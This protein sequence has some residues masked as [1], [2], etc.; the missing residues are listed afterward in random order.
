MS[1][2]IIGW[3]IG[4]AHIKAALLSPD[5]KLLDLA[6]LACP[7]WK[8]LEH[9]HQ[10][11]Q[12]VLQAFSIQDGAH[13][14]TMTGE[15]VDLFENRQQGV[16]TIIQQ[17][18]RFIPAQNLLVYA[19][20]QG[21]L[22]PEQVGLPQCMNIASAN[23]LASASFVASAVEN[24]LFVDMGSTTTDILMIEAHRVQANGYTDYQ[25]LVAEELIYTGMVRT[26]VIAVAQRALFRQQEMPL[27]AEF[28]ASM[29]DVYRLTGDLNEAHDLSETAD[30]GPK[31]VSGSA[32]RLSRLT[33]YDFSPQDMSLWRTF[34]LDI[35][36][37][38]KQLIEKAIQKQ[39]QRITSRDISI[40]GAGI[41]RA[42]IE[43]IADENGYRYVDFDQ[44]IETCESRLAL[45]S[46]DCAPAAAVAS[47]ALL[48][49]LV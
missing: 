19:G 29:A 41:G 10:A 39:I 49:S 38:Q 31:T 14:L 24:G 7:L 1:K 25:R 11:V 8:G 33:G 27:M 34:A 32:R 40:I 47:L 9:L 30:G 35:K 46:S 2:T 26:P 28:F 44:L 23:W 6:L 4:G 21:F 22:R 42:I 48:S 15:L 37:R 3:D 5:G 12:K 18:L 36:Q 17:M 45:S 13:V 20:K 43:E 16:E